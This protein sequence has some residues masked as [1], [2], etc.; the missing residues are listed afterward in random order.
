MAKKVE[1]GALSEPD[2]RKAAKKA[3][4]T[5]EMVRLRDG[6][7]LSVEV[8]PSGVGYWRMRWWIDGVENKQSFGVWP[9]VGLSTART[10]RTEARKLIAEDGVDPSEKRKADKKA[11]AE[12][13][14]AERLAAEGKPGPDT[15]EYIGLEWHREVHSSK[16]T[17]DHAER[18]LIRMQQDLFPWIGRMPNR[19]VTAPVLLAC[20]RRVEARGA[21]ET[22]HRI[23]FIAGQIQRYAI[24][25]GK[26]DRDYTADL[27]D[28]LK[29]P[30]VRHHAA[31]T[32]PKAVAQL[33]SDMYGYRGRPVTR[34][35]LQLSALWILR[36]GEVR[37]TEWTWVDW[38]D[39]L[40]VV[41]GERMKRKKAEKAAGP[42]LVPLTKQ[43]IEILRDLQKL[44]GDGKYLFPNER[45]R[46]RCMSENTVRGALRNLGYSNDDMT[47]HGFRATARTM[48]AEQVKLPPVEAAHSWS[49]VIHV[50]LAHT[51]KSPHGEAYD[52]AK[53][54]PQRRILMRA[55][56]DFLDG[57]R[58]GAKVPPLT[59]PAACTT[60]SI[61]GPRRWRRASHTS[62]AT[63]A[64]VPSTWPLSWRCGFA[65]DVLRS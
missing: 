45:T 33:L 9:D 3:K 4:E 53:Y 31:L 55:W 39:D 57:L 43:A 27:R 26:G 35:A 21:I 30:E 25:I 16:C 41:P 23:K 22:A 13:I 59:R 20:L 60:S 34:A 14:E 11:N 18:T 51:T 62:L 1:F 37:H 8:Q 49:E 42:H 5:G 52:R 65:K 36:P 54:L 28:A 61:P 32:E 7:G 38:D 50:Q 24:T 12:R 47:A 46:Q 10:K 17:A 64:S 6:G 63:T 19:G 15:F 44:T 56:S 2:I 48:L 29:T 58:Q 40:L